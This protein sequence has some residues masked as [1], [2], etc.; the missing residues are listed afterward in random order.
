MHRE[1]NKWVPAPLVDVYPDGTRWELYRLENGVN[2]FSGRVVKY[3][4]CDKYPEGW[5]A[6]TKEG[7]IIGPLESCNEAAKVLLSSL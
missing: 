6:G 3:C 1:Y 5:Y 7:K 4:P 2:R